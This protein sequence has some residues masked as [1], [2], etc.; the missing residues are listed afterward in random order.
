MVKSKIKSIDQLATLTQD[1]FIAAEKRF[2]R[3]ESKVDGLDQRVEKL[4]EKV[5]AGFKAI[6]DVLDVMRD[7][8]HDVKVTLGPLVRTVA[9]LEDSVRIL[10]KR[11]ARLEAKAGVDR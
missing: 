2:E 11:V 9:A 4:E 5:D 1:E 8:L 3:L 10:D 7:D 6:V